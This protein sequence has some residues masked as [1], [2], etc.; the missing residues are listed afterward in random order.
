[1]FLMV[2]VV[3]LIPPGESSTRPVFA[4]AA[5][6]AL[7][8]GALTWLY[9]RASMRALMPALMG[10]SSIAAVGV[11]AVAVGQ[12]VYA[13]LRAGDWE[14]YVLVCGLVVATHAL[15]VIV[16]LYCWKKRWSSAP[17]AAFHR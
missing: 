14:F 15:T 8:Y 7:L 1:V 4:A 12:G 13:A 6:G 16:Y 11:A 17:F 3:W 9:F 10:L 2:A 5:V